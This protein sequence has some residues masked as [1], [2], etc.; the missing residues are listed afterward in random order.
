MTIRTT[1][2]LVCLREDAGGALGPIGLHTLLLLLGPWRFLHPYI[3]QFLVQ[4]VF[5]HAL[6]QRQQRLV[7][8]SLRDSE[9]SLPEH[10]GVEH[11]LLVVRYQEVQDVV[12]RVA[13]LGIVLRF[14]VSFR[15]RIR[16]VRVF[17]SIFLGV[18]SGLLRGPVDP[19]HMHEWSGVLVV[20]CHDL[21]G[22]VGVG[23]S[24]GLPV[25]RK[26]LLSHKL[27]NLFPDHCVAREPVYEEMEARPSPGILRFYQ[28][29]AVVLDEKVDELQVMDLTRPMQHRP[30][31]HVS[32]FHQKVASF[33]PAL[34]F[35]D[36]FRRIDGGID[37]REQILRFWVHDAE[38]PSISKL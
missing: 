1:C 11:A 16:I 7:P 5:Q 36:H 30:V 37:L 35:L 14:F 31:F 32:R 12:V 2:R 29:I 10:I 25:S 9:C 15:V 3:V 13:S 18:L 26:T 24:P 34:H 4:L 28:S 21:R 6:H 22:E 27:I 23:G 8:L 20:F 38:G 33:Q 17:I 19:A